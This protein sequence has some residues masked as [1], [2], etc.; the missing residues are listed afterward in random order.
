MAGHAVPGPLSLT[1]PAPVETTALL[2]ADHV[3]APSI[4]LCWSSNNK[5]YLTHIQLLMNFQNIRIKNKYVKKFYKDVP[6]QTRAAPWFYYH[7]CHILYIRSP[8]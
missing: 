3:H 7:F 4:P 5:P 8:A 2:G 6:K 1:D